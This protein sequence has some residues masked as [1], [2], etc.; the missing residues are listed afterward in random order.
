MKQRAWRNLKPGQLPDQGSIPIALK[1][2]GLL[3]PAIFDGSRRFQT[4][5][6]QGRAV[7]QLPAHPFA[8]LQLERGGEWQGDIGEEP[9][10]R[11]VASRE[12]VTSCGG[13]VFMAMCRE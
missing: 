13:F 6:A 9:G 1:P 7:Q 2:P 5:E 3:F 11:D 4:D 8:R 12:R 10:W